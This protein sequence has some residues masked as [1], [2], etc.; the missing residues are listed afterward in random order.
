MI[1]KV[2]ILGTEYKVHLDVSEQEDSSLDGRYGYC[3]PKARKIV[4]AD[5]NTIDSW[6]NEGEE[7]K[8]RL[9]KETKRH[10]VIHAFLAESGLW[11]SA[12]GCD[13]WALNEEMVDWIA[14]QWPK[15]RK[16]F[17]LLDCDEVE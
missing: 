13:C 8:Q 1:K 7:E 16:V 12:N 2:S 5:L 9:L 3:F 10:E 17:T 11:G 14:V 4:I 6:K 15:I